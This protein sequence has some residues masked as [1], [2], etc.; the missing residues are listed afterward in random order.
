MIPASVFASQVSRRTPGHD[1]NLA[2]F[3]DCSGASDD[4][5][6][7]L[8]SRHASRRFVCRLCGRGRRPAPTRYGADQ[9]RVTDSAEGTRGKV[10]RDESP[11]DGRRRESRLGTRTLIVVILLKSDSCVHGGGRNGKHPGNH[12]KCISVYPLT[13]TL[14]LILGSGVLLRRLRRDQQRRGRARAQP[15]PGSI[16]M[17]T[18]TVIS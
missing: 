13:R 14:V 5:F 12:C 3:H 9:G 18:R 16:E 10:A 4:R 7:C 15:R 17:L 11:H 6:V 2:G 1:G 8:S